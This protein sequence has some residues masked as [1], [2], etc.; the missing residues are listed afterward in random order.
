MKPHL[1]RFKEASTWRGLVAVI[2]ALGVTL[3]PEQIAAIVSAGMGL[4]GLIG[5]FTADKKQ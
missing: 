5:V 4:A 2:T 1:D 3:N